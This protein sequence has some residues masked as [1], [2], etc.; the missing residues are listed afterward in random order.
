LEFS[1]TAGLR[2]LTTLCACILLS[3]G[4]IPAAQT[5]S[6]ENPA[7]ILRDAVVSAC[8][9]NSDEFRK[10]LTARNAEAFVRIAPAA[11]S[12]FLKRFVLLDKTGQP[13][14]ENTSNDSYLVSCSNTD[15]TTQIQIGKVEMRD[16]LS[17]IQFEIKDAAD[18][19]GTGTRH[20]I[21]GMVREN[22]H[23][24]LL[25]LGL[26]LLD[27][28]SLEEEWDRAEIQSNEKAAI[29]YL[30]ELAAAV[31]TYRKSYTRLPDSLATLGPPPRG[32]AGKMDKA[33]LIDPELAAGRKEGYTFRYVIVGASTSGAPAKYELAAIPAEY[34]RS[35]TISFFRDSNGAVHAA[36][37]QGAVGSQ[38][39]PK[40]E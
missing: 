16:N 22:G 33:G 5:A 30:K 13:K 27:L 32:G 3:P 10:A 28:P 2:F 18:S 26:L 25:S 23:W 20:A 31:E 14:S 9:Q 35:G 7:A 19:S 4:N 17:Y 39:D 24:K 6:N 37:R 40:L 21:I 8:S 36:D 1:R 38:I 11:R 12:T 34:G 15:A 29:A